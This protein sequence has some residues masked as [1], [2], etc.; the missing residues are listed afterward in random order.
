MRWF[1]IGRRSDRHTCLVVATYEGPGRVRLNGNRISGGPAK[2]NA[3]AHA[4]TVC[5]A[6]FAEDGARR[7]QGPGPMAGRLADGQ[8]ERLLRELPQLAACRELLRDLADGRDRSGRWLN[9]G[10]WV[11]PDREDH[12][13]HPA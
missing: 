10:A 9:A 7:D 1:N 13:G 3:A 6:E 5:W 8:A 11:G 2:R 12:R 4:Q